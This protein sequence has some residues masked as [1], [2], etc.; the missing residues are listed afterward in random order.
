MKSSAIVICLFLGLTQ[1]VKY[2]VVNLQLDSEALNRSNIRETLKS[3]LREALAKPEAPLEH[4]AIQLE[5]CTYNDCDVTDYNH[6][7][8]APVIPGS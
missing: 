2:D 4:S 1:A 3:Q 7:Y 6:S 8:P 5:R